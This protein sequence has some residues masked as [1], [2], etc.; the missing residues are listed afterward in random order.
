MPGRPRVQI[1]REQLENLH[2]SAGFRWADVARI[3][4]VSARTSIYE[5]GIAVGEATEF[6]NISDHDLDNAVREISG[7][8]P[9]SGQRLVEGGLRQRGLRIQRRRIQEAIRRVDPVVCTL[10]ASRHIIRRVYSVPCAN[11]L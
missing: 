4:G 10:R 2:G 8:T 11:A 9:N 5:H 7:T 6:S 1:F 3:L